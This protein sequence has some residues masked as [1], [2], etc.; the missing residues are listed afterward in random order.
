[1]YKN[2]KTQKGISLIKLIV[3]IVIIIVGIIFDVKMSETPDGI[4]TVEEEQ[5]K[6]NKTLQEKE[7]A[8]QQYQQALNNVIETTTRLEELEKGN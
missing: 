5:E 3:I 8:E 6:Y 2:L 4:G 1:M 7:K